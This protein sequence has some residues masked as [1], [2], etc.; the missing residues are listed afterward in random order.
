MKVHECNCGRNFQF[1]VELVIHCQDFGHRA[2]DD[3]K[4]T[5]SNQPAANLGVSR[6][7]G[8]RRYLGLALMAV[9][10][11]GIDFLAA[12]ALGHYTAWA[13]TAS[14]LVFP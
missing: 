13:G 12:Q 4:T 10:F 9:S 7:S 5:L 11:L 8:F 6:R 1:K 3:K 14:V 2:V